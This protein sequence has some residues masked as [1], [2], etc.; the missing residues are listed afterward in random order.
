MIRM[1]RGVVCGRTIELATNPG[2][3]DRQEVEIT[4]KVIPK[5]EPWGEGLRRCAGASASDWTDKDDRIL[6]E[7]HADRRRDS[8]RRI[9]D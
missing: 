4:I 5:P 8:S 2:V 6:Q 9:L 7:I 1:I 3:G